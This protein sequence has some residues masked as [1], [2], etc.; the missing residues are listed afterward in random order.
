MAVSVER[1]CSFVVY[2]CDKLV[3]LSGFE[4]CVFFGGFAEQGGFWGDFSGD[5]SGVCRKLPIS[6]TN[7]ICVVCVRSS[8][9]KTPAVLCEVLPGMAASRRSRS[10][11]RPKKADPQRG[12]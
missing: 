5:F 3:A 10:E 11:V 7:S 9:E 2:S 12:R 8:S 1:V 4:M 6:W